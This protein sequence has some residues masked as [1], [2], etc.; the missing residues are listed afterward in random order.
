MSTPFRKHFSENVPQ[1]SQKQSRRRTGACALAQRTKG[2]DMLRHIRSRI[3]NICSMRRE[4]FHVWLAYMS[5][6]FSNKPGDFA[7]MTTC[8]AALSRPVATPPWVRAHCNKGSSG[9]S[10]PK[11]PVPFPL[12]FP[13]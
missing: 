13:W 6:A 4:Q 1:V 9:L 10:T 2:P 11:F 7:V 12:H 8:F 5:L 3:L